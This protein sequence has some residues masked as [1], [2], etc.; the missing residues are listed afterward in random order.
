MDI[1][2]LKK[3]QKLGLIP[4][5]CKLKPANISGLQKKDLYSLE[6]KVLSLELQVKYRTKA[7]IVQEYHNLLQKVK[8]EVSFIS[9]V[10]ILKL[11]RSSAKV[12]SN[13]VK[14]RHSVKQS[15]LNKDEGTVHCLDTDKIV[16]NLSACN[17]TDTEVCLLR[18]G[19]A[20][21]VTPQQL[22]SFD[23]R[24]SFECF[25]RQLSNVVSMNSL[26]RLK[27]R[28]QHLSYTYVY[29]YNPNN[30]IICQKMNSWHSNNFPKR[31][32]LSSVSRI[33]VMAL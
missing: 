6:N 8:S 29:G 26:N 1:I 20:F 31:R 18:R 5:F 33:R 14:Q 17:L 21:C 7:T 27:H 30:N 15:K 25:Y 2:F 16:V 32:T 24:T 12:F 3:C 11:I 10:S 4:G 22:N 9:Y 19:L 13:S 23:I 28:L